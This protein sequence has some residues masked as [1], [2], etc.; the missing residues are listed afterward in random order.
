MLAKEA[1]TPIAFKVLPDVDKAKVVQALANVAKD[2]ASKKKEL[3]KEFEAKAPA[4]AAVLKANKF[5]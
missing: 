1:T 4:D 3:G 2:S 5:L